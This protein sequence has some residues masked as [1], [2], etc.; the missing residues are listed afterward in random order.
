[1][2]FTQSLREASAALS[3]A[4]KALDTAR[5]DNA[6]LK[7]YATGGPVS[8]TGTGTSDSIAAMLS[9]GEFV[10]KADAASKHRG[11][12][13]K[14]NAG[15]K[16]QKFS[17][18]TPAASS[19]DNR[20]F[21]QFIQIDDKGKFDYTKTINEFTK[22]LDMA[23][24]KGKRLEAMFIS[25][26]DNTDNLNGQ[27][28]LK[29]GMAKEANRL[30]LEM[31]NDQK[32]MSYI[33]KDLAKS[34]KDAAG[35]IAQVSEAIENAFKGMAKQASQPFKQALTDSG[36]LMEALKEGVYGLY[37]NINMKLLDASFAPAEKALDAM[38]NEMFGGHLAELGASPVNPMYTTDSSSL[39]D[40]V[41]ESGGG[42][43]DWIGAMVSGLGAMMSGVW[44]S[45]TGV[46][47]G[48]FATQTAT[49]TAL[50]T[51][52]T[53]TKLS[54][55][56][57]QTGALVASISSIGGATIGVL[58]GGF[59]SVVAAVSASAA[60]GAAGSLLGLAKGG[61]VPR[62]QYL[63]S[64]GFAGGPRG[65]DTVP[66]WLTP[67]EM[68]LNRDQQTALG[69]AMGNTINQTINISGNVDDRAIQ[70]IQ[71]ITRNVISSDSGL[72]ANSASVGQRRGAGL[73][74][75]INSRR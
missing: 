19:K 2:A 25:L 58:T 34:S 44:S 66:A 23:T 67:G 49:N 31:I 20:D 29:Q 71:A 59:G 16:I 10:V 24:G 18:G 47:S 48:L 64:G 26:E 5:G 70:Q 43:G 9:N 75:G 61:V 11:L 15:G 39:V 32:T 28:I 63:A 33:N 6:S 69:G 21:F 40:G 22:G 37:Q 74:K 4:V 60:A 27:E 12:L 62:A 7:G 30:L 53:A 56:A 17:E 14:I 65:T 50:S 3:L 46:F 42:F 54:S 38:I 45:I 8:G 73:N 41:V 51:T 55:E 1:M 57:M 68:V 36:D 13:D 52:E 72:V 35:A